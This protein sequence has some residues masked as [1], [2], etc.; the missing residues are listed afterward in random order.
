[1]AKEPS[2]RGNWV[3]LFIET[4]FPWP[5]SERALVF[6]GF[7]IWL[8]PYTDDYMPMVA[9]DCSEQ[10]ISTDDG[11]K[12]LRQFVSAL[13]WSEERSAKIHGGGG[14]TYAYRMHR[15]SRRNPVRS[16]GGVPHYDYLPEPE[17]ERSLLGLALYREAMEANNV[18]F[19]VLG[20]SK[21]FNVIH[22]SSRDQKDWIN[23][24]LGEIQKSKDR[25]AELQTRNVD[26]GHYIYESCRCAVAHAYSEPLVNPD[27]PADYLRL[28][29]DLEL[30]KELAEIAIEQDLGVKSSMTIFREHLYELKGFRELLGA[31]LV[32]LL[33]SSKLTKQRGFEFPD[34][35]RLTIRL[36][37]LDSFEALTGLEVTDIEVR[38][39]GM[40]RVRCDSN[41]RT[42]AVY[43]YLH[44]PEER[45][46]IDVEG[47]FAVFDTGTPQAAR[48]AADVCQFKAK[49]FLNGVLEIWNAD[50]GT[51][52]GRCDPF[53]PTNIM[54]VETAQ[55]FE[56]HAN[57]F[58]EIAA[59]R[60][61]VD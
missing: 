8:L 13:V 10:R 60:E 9:L 44:F 34:F 15:Q 32:G 55:N 29:R 33:K 22:R 61:R 3:T 28:G 27:D 16:L 51:L 38:V 47:G 23:S 43:L 59:E 14:G 52:M 6:R 31:E 54:P 1:M 5:E 19:Q 48:Y 2:Q 46:L 7:N 21:I 53:I 20:F 49:Y 36:R 40:V 4:E 41:D 56:E 25:L 35:P 30:V 42:C 57:R 37:D 17:D 11:Y 12:L 26:I 39:D 45:L 58:L 50:D 18:A 24:R